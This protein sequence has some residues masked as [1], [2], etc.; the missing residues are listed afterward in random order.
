MSIL[1]ETPSYIA[2]VTNPTFLMQKSMHDISLQVDVGKL[3]INPS[4]ELPYEQEMYYKMDMDFINSLIFR[5]RQ[6]TINDFDIRQ[7][8]SQYTKLI[9]DVA[10]G[11]AAGLQHQGVELGTIF[12]TRTRRLRQTQMFNTRELMQKLHQSDYSNGTSLFIV[13]KQ[14]NQLRYI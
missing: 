3:I 14:L 1:M 10:T 9:F 8:F 13:E 12:A 6:N 4:N 5:I 2:G 7:A 11:Q